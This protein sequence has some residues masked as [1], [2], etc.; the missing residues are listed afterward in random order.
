MPEPQ[1][2]Q[3]QINT[4]SVQKQQPQQSQQEDFP[5]HDDNAEGNCPYCRKPITNSDQ[6]SGQVGML[7]STECYHQFHVPCFKAYLKT[8]LITPKPIFLWHW[9]HSASSNW[10]SW[11]GPAAGFGVIRRVFR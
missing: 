4:S 5:M 1:P 9:L 3:S 6:Q 10:H 7:L 8:R 11:P 2:R